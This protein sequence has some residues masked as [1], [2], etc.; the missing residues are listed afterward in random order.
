MAALG[1]R[2]V[3]ADQVYVHHAKSASFGAERRA[4]LAAEG[5]AALKHLHPGV[6]FSALGER[7]RETIPLI[8]MRD[9]V[10]E[11]LKGAG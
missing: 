2:L 8:R 7:M 9:A 5:M 11:A 4:R 1:W 3:V 10:R 6:D